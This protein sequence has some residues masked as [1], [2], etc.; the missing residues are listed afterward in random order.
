MYMANSA[1]ETPVFGQR[2]EP[3]P[4]YQ[5]HP[6]GCHEPRS[7]T[8]K[9][10]VTYLLVVIDPKKTIPRSVNAG[11]CGPIIRRSRTTISE[12]VTKETGLAD[13]RVDEGMV[14]RFRPARSMKATSPL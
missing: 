7:G 1:A 12:P 10:F 9:R 5:R 3:R 8:S 14:R 13:L 11:Q 2:T 6:N 4:S